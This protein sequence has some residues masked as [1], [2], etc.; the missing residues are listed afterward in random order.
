MCKV[1]IPFRS[2]ST[3]VVIGGDA[4]EDANNPLLENVPR[5]PTLQAAKRLLSSS[6][7]SISK[8]LPVRSLQSSVDAIRDT[9]FTAT[10]S[11]SLPGSSACSVASSISFGEIDGQLQ[12]IGVSIGPATGILGRNPSTSSISTAPFVRSL[13]VRRWRIVRFA[14]GGMMPIQYTN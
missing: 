14:K 8:T 1:T 12:P 7:I 2:Y 10:C 11:G 6:I 13:D 3:D 5:V 4:S 9:R